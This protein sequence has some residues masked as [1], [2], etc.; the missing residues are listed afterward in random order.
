M[1]ILISLATNAIDGITLVCL[2]DI[3]FGKKNRL[4][5]YNLMVILDLLHTFWYKRMQSDM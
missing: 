2:C 5:K 4:N 1:E 3:V